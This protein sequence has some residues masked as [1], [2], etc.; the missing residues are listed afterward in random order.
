MGQSKRPRPTSRGRLGA[1]LNSPPGQTGKVAET[2]IMELVA[3]ASLS[4]NRPADTLTE[5][6]GMGGHVAERGVCQ[7]RDRRQKPDA[8]PFLVGGV[9]IKRRAVALRGRGE[10][11]RAF[12]QCALLLSD[13][14]NVLTRRRREILSENLVALHAS[15]ECREHADAAPVRLGLR[16]CRG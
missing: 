8:P 6:L 15:G 11:L 14:R 10:Q 1:R 5:A 4:G 3:D 16:L 13:C 9:R 7:P 2:Q 12:R